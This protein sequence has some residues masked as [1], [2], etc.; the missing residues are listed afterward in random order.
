MLSG[1]IFQISCSSEARVRMKILLVKAVIALPI[2][3]I[4]KLF[5]DLKEQHVEALNFPDEEK[6]LK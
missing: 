4:I 5:S 1:L 3:V 6:T 2:A